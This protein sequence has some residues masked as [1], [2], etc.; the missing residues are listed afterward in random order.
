MSL[1]DINSLSHTKWN[2]KYHIVFA[3]KYRR[4]VFYKEK[5]A[6]S[7]NPCTAGRPYTRL[8]VTRGTEGFAWT[9][10]DYADSTKSL[11]VGY[12]VLSGVAQR[13]R[14]HS[15]FCLDAF[16]VI[17]V[18]IPVDQFVRFLERLWLVAVDALCF[19]NREEIFCHGIVIRISF[20]D[21]DGVMP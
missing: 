11:H 9:A 13:Q 17:E 8:R 16:V 4:K 10:P 12:W 3:P 6:A 5:R 18:N 7:N 1:N 15:R 20:L 14:Y 21:M 19:Q 2:C